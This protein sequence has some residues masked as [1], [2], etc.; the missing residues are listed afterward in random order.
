MGVTVI[1]DVNAASAGGP[2]VAIALA[3]SARR[4]VTR[5]AL[6]GGSGMQLFTVGKPD[7]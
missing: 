4:E 5:L 6:S 1:T 7:A 2:P 3:L